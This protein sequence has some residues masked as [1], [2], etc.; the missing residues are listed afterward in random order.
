MNA[1]ELQDAKSVPL[2]STLMIVNSFVVTT[3]RFLNHF[4]QLA[5]EKLVKIN[6][7]ITK[8]EVEVTL[9]GY[10]LCSMLYVQPCLH[11][12]PLASY[13]ELYNGV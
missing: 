1:L 13:E 11:S 10:P 8:L 12:R 4:S 2:Q 6:N 3:V 5:E 9:V 7:S